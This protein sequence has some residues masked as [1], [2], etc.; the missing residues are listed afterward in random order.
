MFFGCFLSA[1]VMFLR[2]RVHKLRKE[3]G[4]SSG[5]TLQ[6]DRSRRWADQPL[7]ASRPEPQQ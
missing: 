5:R 6:P 4:W 2:D 7:D 3:R 1:A